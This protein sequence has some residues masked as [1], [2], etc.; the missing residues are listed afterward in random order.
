VAAAEV[1]GLQGSD[2]ADPR[3]MAATAK[4]FAGYGAVEAGRDYNTV[5]MSWRRFHELHLP[6]F[7]AAIDAGLASVM[8]AFISLNGIPA[9]ENKHLLKDILRKECGFGGVVVSD[10][11]AI[12]EMLNHRVAATSAQAA[13]ESMHAGMDM[14]L[15]SGTYFETLPGLVKKGKVSEAELDSAVKNVLTLKF[16]LGLFDH[17]FLYG[18]K[19]AAYQDSLLKKHRPWA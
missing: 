13:E 16:K 11:D 10:Y 15:H 7:Q 12:P 2:L 6:P 9:S 4:H 19:P 17:P 3:T 14:D 18:N 8:P 5:D 1:K